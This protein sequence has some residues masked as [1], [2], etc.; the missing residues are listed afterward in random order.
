MDTSGF[1]KSKIFFLLDMDHFVPQ[2]IFIKPILNR[3]TGNVS[4]VFIDKG[5]YMTENLSR[6]DHFIHIVEGNAEV[7]IDDSSF[8]LMSGESL[9]IPAHSKNMIKAN[10]RFKMISTIIKSGYE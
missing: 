1:E 4:A 5:E 8:H 3:P 2:G 6:F 7:L 9:I 10:Q